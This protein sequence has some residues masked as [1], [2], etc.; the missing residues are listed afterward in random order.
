MLFR[1]EIRSPLTVGLLIL[2]PINT[3][4]VVK[5]IEADC[6]RSAGFLESCSSGIIQLPGKLRE[7]YQATNSLAAKQLLQYHQLTYGLKKSAY[8]PDEDFFLS[9]FLPSHSEVIFD[10]EAFSAKAFFIINFNR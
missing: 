10:R 5:L 7:T 2:K 3:N 8:F 1:S 9:K 6:I 4:F